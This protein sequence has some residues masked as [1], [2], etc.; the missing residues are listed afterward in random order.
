MCD[1]GLQAASDLQH[2]FLCVW[3]AVLT[4]YFIFIIYILTI[5]L[6]F[7]Q[8]S[9][10]M[11]AYIGLYSWWKSMIMSL[12]C[13]EGRNISLSLPYHYSHPADSQS[14]SK[15]TCILPLSQTP[16]SS[17]SCT[18]LD[19]R[20]FVCLFAQWPY[21]YLMS[22]SQSPWSVNGPSRALSLRECSPIRALE[23]CWP[24]VH[25]VCEM[26]QHCILKRAKICG[27][28]ETQLY[29]QIIISSC[30]WCISATWYQL[31]IFHLVY[32]VTWLNVSVYLNVCN[33]I[34]Q[35]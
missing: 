14:E 19:Y 26:S 24:A 6:L 17:T 5:N 32:T 4:Q 1:E 15:Y 9:W 2:S 7:I 33:C 10:R 12:C 34:N 3:K 29:I 27:Y 13:V 23:T 8:L 28:T 35:D 22:V 16:S 31:Q 25:T 20:V 21:P 11:Y 18:A 30:P